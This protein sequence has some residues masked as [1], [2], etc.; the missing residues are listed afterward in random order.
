MRS[1]VRVML[2]VLLFVNCNVM[3][4]GWTVGGN[5][6]VNGGRIGTNTA[7]DLIFETDNTTRGRVTRD[8]LWGFGTSSPSAKVHVG[9]AVGQD[10]FKVRVGNDLKLW[11]D[12]LGGTS[13][14]GISEPPANGLLV[15]G[16]TG[17]GSAPG[18]YKVKITHGTFGFDIE[19]GT[20]LD[21]WELWSNSG[22]LS[23]YANS[24]FRGNFN[25]TTGAYT[26]VSDERVKMNIQPMPSV[27]AKVSKLQPSTYQ[28]HQDGLMYDATV[29]YG[30]IAQDVA[31]VFPHLVE[32]HYEPERGLDAYTMDYSG[33]GVIAI[34]AIQELQQNVNTLEARIAQLEAAL[35]QSGP[36]KRR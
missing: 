36:P 14:G 16:N 13:I 35:G 5:N 3:A 1:T 22:G 31:Q 7:A 9:S 21:D 4:Q 23:L 28:Y 8:G 18:S 17:L 33:F 10:P 24:G 6:L 2:G 11:V 30:F 27:L 26:S 34:K 12:D 25:P 19:N 20:T 29:R 15:A 32:Y